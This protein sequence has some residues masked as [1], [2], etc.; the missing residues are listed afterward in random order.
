MAQP[1]KDP[2]QLK[3]ERTPIGNYIVQIFDGKRYTF[4]L[5]NVPLTNSLKGGAA[6]NCLMILGEDI[7]G[8]NAIGSIL[9]MSAPFSEYGSN[10]RFRELTSSL[11][12]Y[13]SE[14]LASRAELLGIVNA[15][16]GTV[17][18]LVRPVCPGDQIHF[19]NRAGVAIKGDNRHLPPI[20]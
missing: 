8:Q 5:W 13:R 20:E 12:S 15:Y 14:H 1:C 11:S 3:L 9:G 18:N 7:V 6:E 16:E 2:Q 19:G 10:P 17:F 4:G